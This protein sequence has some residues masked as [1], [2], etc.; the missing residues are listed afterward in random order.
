MLKYH[1]SYRAERKG[2]LAQAEYRI[3]DGILLPGPDKSCRINSLYVLLHCIVSLS[4]VLSWKIWDFLLRFE[5]REWRNK[6]IINSHLTA[7]KKSI[8]VKISV[9]LE[10]AWY[11]LFLKMLPC[12]LFPVEWRVHIVPRTI[13]HI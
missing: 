2:K 5:I 1:K 4:P 7:V 11:T 3:S 6:Q 8:F 10:L 9:H 13:L 12:S